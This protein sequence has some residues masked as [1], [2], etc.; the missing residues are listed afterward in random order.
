LEELFRCHAGAVYRYLKALT[1]DASLAEELTAE[2]L[3][4]AYLALDGFRGEASLRTWVLRIARNTYYRRARKRA[5]TVSLDALLEAGPGLPAPGGDPECLV[6][7]QE[8]RV[9]MVRALAEL[10]EA[11]RELL[12]LHYQQELLLRDVA[13]VLGISLSAVKVRLLRARRRLAQE[14]TRLEQAH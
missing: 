10:N 4:R 14:F 13:E 12:L 9:L 6:L 8:Q 5:D 1:G 3:F 11:D 2:T 7:E